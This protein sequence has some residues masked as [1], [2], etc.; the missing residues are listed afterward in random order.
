[1]AL[2]EMADPS[3]RR[4]TAWVQRR[5]AL[6]SARRCPAGSAG[7]SRRSTWLGMRRHAQTATPMYQEPGADAAERLTCSPVTAVVY[8]HRP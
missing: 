2:S 4:F 8:P 5:C 3:W 6:P 1:M 7:T